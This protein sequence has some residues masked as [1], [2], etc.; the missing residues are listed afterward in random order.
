LIRDHYTNV[1]LVSTTRELSDPISVEDESFYRSAGIAFVFVGPLLD[2]PGAKRASGAA[3][4]QQQQEQKLME[5]V[6]SAFATNRPIVYVSM[7]TV[8]TSDD[9]TH[10]WNAT[11][12][13]AITGRQL[14]HAVFRGV[15]AEL[16][17]PAAATEHGC[18]GAV[19]EL[20]VSPLIVVSTGSQPDA[21]DGVEV[22]QNA[23][24]AAS[25]P[26]VDL[27]RTGKPASPQTTRV[28]GLEV[29]LHNPPTSVL[30]CVRV[31]GLGLLG[32]R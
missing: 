6:K 1:N 27:L 4:Q 20:P 25:V 21:L 19:E 26:Q 31:G 30:P 23:V 29:L 5:T 8:I 12:G 2:V 3:S 28:G 11:S 13:S 15:F 14:C 32:Q 9:D 10:G 7:G 22:P 16:G 24:C 17:V 18:K